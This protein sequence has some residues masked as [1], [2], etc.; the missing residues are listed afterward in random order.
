MQE[1]LDP[2]KLPGSGSILFSLDS[3]LYEY[4]PRSGSVSEVRGGS[5]FESLIRS[6]AQ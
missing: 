1:D 6:I 5:G 3:D 4:L 2:Y